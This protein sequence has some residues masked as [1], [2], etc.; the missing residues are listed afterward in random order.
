MGA[1]KGADSRSTVT[2]SLVGKGAAGVW[3]WQ[4]HQLQPAGLALACS[5]A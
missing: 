4:K 3:P 1:D 2:G 5:V